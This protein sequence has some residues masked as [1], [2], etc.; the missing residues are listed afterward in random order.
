[1]AVPHGQM[2]AALAL[3][4]SPL[5]AVRTV[6]VPQAVRIV[7]PPVTNDFIALFKDTSVCS[8]ILITELTRKYNELYNFNRDLHRRVGVRDCRTLPDHELPNGD[9]GEVAGDKNEMIRVANI[10]KSFGTNRILDGVSVEFA[11]GQVIGIVGPSGS[12]KSTLLRCV[13]GFEPFEGGEISVGDLNLAGGTSPAKELLLKLRRSVGMVFQSFNLFPHMSVLANVMS[14]PIHALGKGR[15]EA[16]AVAR[17]LLDRVG[18]ADKAESRPGQLSGGQQQR[19]A[20]ARLWRLTPRRS[21]STN[22]PAP[23]IPRCPRR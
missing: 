2:E 7:I 16:Q 18:L 14:G 11:K 21:C 13:N 19:V 4:M 6:I 22:R 9:S 12:G 23:S 1:M 15:S 5:T 3:G 17:K 10:V 8:V 20:I